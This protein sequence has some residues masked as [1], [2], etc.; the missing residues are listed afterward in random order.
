MDIVKEPAKI[1][2]TDAL[3]QRLEKRI[4]ID[5][6]GDLRAESACE[7]LSEMIGEGDVLG[8]DDPLGPAARAL[9][10][11]GGNSAYTSVFRRQLRRDQ[12]DNERKIIAR[13][14]FEWDGK[15]M[16]EARIKSWLQLRVNHDPEFGTNNLEKLL[17]YFQATDFR[18]ADSPRPNR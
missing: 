16:G 14:I 4:A 7:L 3:Q 2:S 11:I 15:E 9:V 13:M 10:K 6:L 5:L 12:S 8:L 17:M 18:V 1:D